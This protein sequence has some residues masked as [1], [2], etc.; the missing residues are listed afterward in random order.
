MNEIKWMVVEW[1]FLAVS[2]SAWAIHETISYRRNK[3]TNDERKMNNGKTS[4]NQTRTA[5]DYRGK[6]ERESRF[7][8]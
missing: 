4:K 8:D 5:L 3:A 2:F 7:R 6:E 1:T